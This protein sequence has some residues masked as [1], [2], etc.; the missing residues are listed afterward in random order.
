[1]AHPLQHSKSSVKKWGGKVEDYIEIHNWFD[2]TK[3]WI[4]FLLGWLVRYCLGIFIIHSYP[5]I[6]KVKL[7]LLWLGRVGY[8]AHTV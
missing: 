5:L 1:M 3:S 2:E 7:A 8:V 4:I 6:V